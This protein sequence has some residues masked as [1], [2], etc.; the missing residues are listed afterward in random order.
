M[1]GFQ[2]PKKPGDKAK[3]ILDPFVV[4]DI[5][6][7]PVDKQSERTR[8]IENNG[9]H[10]VWNQKMTFKITCPHLALVLFRVYDSETSRDV[11]VAQYSLP[12][13]CMQKGY[14]TVHL[15]NKHGEPMMVGSLFVKIEIDDELPIPTKQSTSKRL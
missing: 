3:M 8:T 7:I 4:V 15:K 1:S 11:V 14:R 2:L 13:R 6:G 10:P 12:F 5:V 9:F